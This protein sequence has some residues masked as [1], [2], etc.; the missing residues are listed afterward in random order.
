M[1]DTPRMAALLEAAGPASIRTLGDPE[2]AQPVGPGG[3]QRLVDPVIGGHAELVAVIRQRH[4][5]DRK[6]CRQIR[7]GHAPEALVDLAARG[8]LHLSPDRSCAVKELVHAWDHHR[9]A[10]GL[11][12]VAIVTDTDN[13]TVD[14]LNALCQ[15]RRLA[16]GELTGPGVAVADLATGRRERLHVG[17]RVRFIR[18]YL[19][20]DLVPVYV[21]NGTGA[22]VTG[23]DPDHGLLTVSCD[24]R[25]TVTLQPAQLEESQPLRLGYASHALKL[26][27]GQAQVVLVLPGGWQTSR[28]SAYSMATRCVEELHVYLDT[29][30]QQTGPYR[31]TDPVRALGE[32]WTRDAKKLA[33]SLRLDHSQQGDRPTGRPT[34]EDDLVMA[35]SGPHEPATAPWAPELSHGRDLGDGLGIDL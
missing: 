20:R 27:G 8:R 16:A 18:P 14:T 3:W 1:V 23:V 5:A 6:V 33:A 26:Q 7:Q 9:H 34:V 19:A 17:D 35:P 10:H 29:A 30:T 22:K 2:Q 11:A 32:R 31:D 13:Q 15:A 24:D 21:A 28:Q 25:R 4:H 12:G